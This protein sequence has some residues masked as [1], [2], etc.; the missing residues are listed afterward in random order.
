MEWRLIPWIAAAIILALSVN[1]AINL[2]TSPR[3]GVLR[4]AMEGRVGEVSE[5]NMTALKAN[6]AAVTP[7]PVFK[8]PETTGMEQGEDLG[9]IAST[10]TNI[11]LSMIIAAMVFLFSRS[12]KM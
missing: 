10:T 9:N 6:M 5:E 11:A 8:S 7:K 3:A 12:R 4:A 1:M 2:F